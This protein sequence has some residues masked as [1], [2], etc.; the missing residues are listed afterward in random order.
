MCFYCYKPVTTH[1][2]E[3]FTELKLLLFDKFLMIETHKFS[4]ILGSSS[5]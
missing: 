3:D 5:F 4:D 2:Q 1:V